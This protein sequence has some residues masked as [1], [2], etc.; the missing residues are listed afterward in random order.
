MGLSLPEV[1]RQLWITLL[2]ELVQAETM[3]FD[4]AI[5]P[6]D[7]VGQMTIAAF[8]DGS[9]VAYSTVL[10]AVWNLDGG[11]AMEVR[12]IASKSKVGENWSTNTLR[13]ELNGAVLMTR[14]V[15]EVVRAL[16][17]QPRKIW[18]SGDSETILAS[19]EKH[20][21]FFSEWFSNRIGETHDNQK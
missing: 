18:L 15:V 8:W 17:L 20:S 14:L 6:F 4:R 13:Q 21:G 9:D 5:N 10:Y 12:L 1:L 11:E 7:A 2:T 19:R 3:E 16:R